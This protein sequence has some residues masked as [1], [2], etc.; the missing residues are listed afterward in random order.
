MFTGSY[1]LFLFVVAKTEVLANKHSIA[2]FRWHEKSL[3]AEGR[4]RER[5][6]ARY[7]LLLAGHLDGFSAR[8]G[9]GGPDHQPVW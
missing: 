7:L 6:S 8:R 9:R 1:I 4:R 2:E 5:Q 3:F